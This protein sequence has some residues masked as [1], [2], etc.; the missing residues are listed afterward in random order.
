VGAQRKL[1]NRRALVLGKKWCSAGFSG[2]KEQNPSVAEW[3][4]AVLRDIRGVRGPGRGHQGEWRGLCAAVGPRC[5]A[6]PGRE[7]L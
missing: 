1:R 4:Y 2:K 7:I 5:V 3:G 6:S